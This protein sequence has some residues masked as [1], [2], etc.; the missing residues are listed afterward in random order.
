MNPAGLLEKLLERRVALAT[1]S[2]SMLLAFAFEQMAS[3]IIETFSRQQLTLGAYALI[4]VFITTS[5]RFF[6][7]NQLHLISD[8]WKQPHPRFLWM[9]DYIIVIFQTIVIVVW[10]HLC[11]PHLNRGI[12]EGL[13]GTGGYKISG[14]DTPLFAMPDTTISP[15]EMDFICLYSALLLTDIYLVLKLIILCI[16]KGIRN[17]CSTALNSQNLSFCGRFSLLVAKKFGSE[18]EVKRSLAWVV[19]HNVQLKWVVINGVCILATWLLPL[20]IEFCINGAFTWSILNNPTSYYYSSVPASVCLIVIGLISFYV[21]VCVADEARLFAPSIKVLPHTIAIDLAKHLTSLAQ[22]TPSK[23]PQGCVLVYKGA[24]EYSAESQES[25]TTHYDTTGTL[26]H[27]ELTVKCAEDL[28]KDQAAT[29]NY[30]PHKGVLL[31]SHR[32]SHEMVAGIVGRMKIKQ[33]VYLFDDVD[34]VSKYS[35]RKCKAMSRKSLSA[36]EIS[37]LEEF[38]NSAR[39]YTA[40]NKSVAVALYEQRSVRL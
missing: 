36:S 37:I 20:T 9:A 10:A 19:S 6:I 23:L 25:I 39:A 16:L 2:V 13:V 32:P 3:G 11:S 30:L 28:L 15:K 17:A 5:V 4:V 14:G 40:N 35:S 7:G 21:D 27:S 26:T 18:D 22:G 8:D 29:K 1:I 33:I 12:S 38:E 31:C 34:N 24:V